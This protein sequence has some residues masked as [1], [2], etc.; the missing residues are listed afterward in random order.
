MQP[1]VV[2]CDLITVWFMV[3]LSYSYMYQDLCWVPQSPST[4]QT[5][6][7]ECTTI[8]LMIDLNWLF[9]IIFKNL[10]LIMIQHYMLLIEGLQYFGLAQWLGVLEW[11]FIKPRHSGVSRFVVH[12]VHLTLLV[13]SHDEQGHDWGPILFQISTNDINTD[14]LIE[15]FSFT[16]IFSVVCFIRETAVVS[17]CTSS[18]QVLP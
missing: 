4:L 17:T 5:I 7:S 16:W 11:A 1:Y 14:D 3:K 10:S 15:S 12:Q 8:M 6:Q 18:T 9:N 13:T 2:E